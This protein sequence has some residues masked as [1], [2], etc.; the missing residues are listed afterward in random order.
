MPSEEK[1]EQLVKK[2]STLVTYRNKTPQEIYDYAR[3]HLE[4]EEIAIEITGK[5]KNKLEKK[6]AKD[7]LLKYLNDYQIETISER[8]TLNEV[9]YLE[10]VQKRLQDRLNE[11]Y[12]KDAKAVPLQMID[13]IHKNSDAIIK[14]KNTLGLNRSRE[15]KLNYDAYQHFIKRA[16]RWMEE[17]QASRTL[18]CPKCQDFIL[19]RMRTSQWEAQKHPF[20]HD[21]F[22]YNKT[23]FTNLDKTVKIDK[24]FIAGVLETSTDY[25]DWII[26]KLGKHEKS[27]QT[28]KE[29]QSGVI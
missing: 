1:I 17:N 7:L 2:L 4:Q 23:L 26:Q 18:K 24:N 25:I 11:Y 6:L 5:F 13:A 3:N 9:I 20:F 10:V 14:L 15:V 28:E 21:N 12:A 19:L 16:K 8:N 29:E 27:I 22:L